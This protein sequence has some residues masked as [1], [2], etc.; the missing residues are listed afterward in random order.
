MWLMVGSPCLLSVSQDN[1]LQIVDA[2]HRASHQS[3]VM[4]SHRRDQNLTHERARLGR[5]L[6]APVR[7]LDF[8]S[9]S[10]KLVSCLHL[11]TRTQVNFFERRV[12]EP[13]SIGRG[14]QR[15]IASLCHRNTAVYARPQGPPGAHGTRPVY[16]YGLGG[17]GRPKRDRTTVANTREH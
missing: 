10:Q 11:G 14:G 12:H 15:G 16:G 1:V 13:Q 17:L 8:H 6:M 7:D 5:E 2:H 3:S 9:L 4:Q